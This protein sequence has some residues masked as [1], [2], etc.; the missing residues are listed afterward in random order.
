MAGC[1]LTLRKTRE[2]ELSGLQTELY[3]KD[4]ELSA[5]K[6]KLETREYEVSGREKTVEREKAH[7]KVL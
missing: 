7:I 4:N 2:D 3:A 6:A 5:L 1:S